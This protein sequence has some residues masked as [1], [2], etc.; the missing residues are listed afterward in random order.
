MHGALDFAW[1]R[2][3]AERS[4][5]WQARHES[6]YAT[7]AWK[8]GAEVWRTDVCVPISRLADS[9]AAAQADIEGS[10]IDGKVLGHVGDGNF[11]VAYLVDPKIE[12][13]REAVRAMIARLNHQAIANGGTVSGEQGIGIAKLPYLLEEHGE[14]ALEAMHLIKRALDPR[15][16]MNPGKMGSEPSSLLKQATQS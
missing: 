8:P 7:S 3:P 2:D 12:S 14:T 13:Q 16:I 15:G 9:I 6:L 4:R 1:S 11:H 5:L 10:G